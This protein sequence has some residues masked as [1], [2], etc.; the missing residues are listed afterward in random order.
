MF[1]PLGVYWVCTGVV[2]PNKVKG[3]YGYLPKPETPKPLNPPLLQGYG[4]P[5]F[6]KALVKGCRLNASELSGS[7]V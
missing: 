6:K 2:I 5:S 3:Y 7:F 4:T 1:I